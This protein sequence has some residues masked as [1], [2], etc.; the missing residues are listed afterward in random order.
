[1]LERH[2]VERVDPMGE[3]F[4]PHLHQAVM[5]MPQ[6][7][8]PAGTVIQVFQSGYTI[9]DRVLRPAMVVVATGGVKPDSGPSEAVAG[10]RPET[11]PGAT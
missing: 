9:A 1:M 8:V 7:D 5:E 4:N 2:G 11:E 3:A 6:A 10:L